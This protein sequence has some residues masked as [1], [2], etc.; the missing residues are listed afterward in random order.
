M[1]SPLFT[2]EL[3]HSHQVIT[4]LYSLLGLQSHIFPHERLPISC[5]TVSTHD[6][7]IRVFKRKKEKNQKYGSLS[8]QF[9]IQVNTVIRMH[10]KV[11]SITTEIIIYVVCVCACSVTSNSLWAHGLYPPGSSV[12]GVF[13]T[14]ILEWVV[15]SSPGDLPDPGTELASPTSPAGG[16]FTTEPPGKSLIICVKVIKITNRSLLSSS[17]VPGTC[18]Q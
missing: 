10:D 16:I 4:L 7:E 2:D 11:A 18:K 8:W 1:S 5:K 15:F 17:Y 13:Q 14:R 12:Y 9:W 3:S 6:G